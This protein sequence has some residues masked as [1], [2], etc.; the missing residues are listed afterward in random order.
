MISFFSTLGDYWIDPNE[1][2]GHDAILVH[3]NA[4]N[5]E[6]CVYSKQPEA[7]KDTW[8]TGKQQ[9]LWA[10]KDFMDEPGLLI[11]LSESLSRRNF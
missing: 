3:C 7:D 2:S 4:T 9:F 8:F 1:G 6:T 10:F 11:S 5:Y